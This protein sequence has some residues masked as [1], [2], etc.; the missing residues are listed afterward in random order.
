VIACVVDPALCV[1]VLCPTRC[2]PLQPSPLVFN[3]A[4]GI[5]RQTP[6]QTPARSARIQRPSGSQ[7][8]SPQTSDVGHPQPTRADLQSIELNILKTD[9]TP[10]PCINPTTLDRSFSS[11]LRERLL[12]GLNRLDVS[13]VDGLLESVAEMPGLRTSSC[14]FLSW[15]RVSAF[16]KATKRC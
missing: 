10:S 1:F 12:V 11:F 7:S 6:N 3:C 14:A 15:M 9:H 5:I 8:Q 16:F 2:I 4:G 13:F